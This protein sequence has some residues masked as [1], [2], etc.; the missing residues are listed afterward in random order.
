MKSEDFSPC[1]L[2]G[3]VKGEAPA[4]SQI[5]DV[6]IN[7]A[8]LAGLCVSVIDAVI[9]RL[10]DEKQINFE[11]DTAKL[12]NYMLENRHEYISTLKVEKEEESE[13]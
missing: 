8:I 11:S 6:E 2:L 13:Y 10:P 9:S 3:L 7:P 4:C 1:F 12:I 5:G